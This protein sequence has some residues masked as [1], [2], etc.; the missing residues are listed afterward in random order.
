MAPLTYLGTIHSV[1]F[2]HPDHDSRQSR[3]TAGMDEDIR[4]QSHSELLLLVM[5]HLDLP[6][7]LGRDTAVRPYQRQVQP[8]RGQLGHIH[9]RG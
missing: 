7:H 8:I 6:D 5:P 3:S 9:P 1:R 4:P 2:L